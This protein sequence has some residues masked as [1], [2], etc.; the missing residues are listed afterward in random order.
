MLFLKRI[1]SLLRT[2]LRPGELDEDLDEELRAWVDLRTAQLVEEG[3]SIEAARRAALIELGGI[4]RVKT[5][6]R[7]RRLGSFFDA[8]G[9]DLRIAMRTVRKEPGFALIAITI[10]AL[11]IGATSAIYS[12]VDRELPFEEPDRLVA[13]LKTIGGEP[14]NWISGSTTTTS[15]TGTVRSRNWRQSPTSPRRRR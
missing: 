10:L 6:V 11:G 12:L 14:A 4:E 8:L 1:Q 15:T 2:V 3:S 5:Q 7:E 13:G 9:T